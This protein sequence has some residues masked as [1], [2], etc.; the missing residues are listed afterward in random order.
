MIGF[1]LPGFSNG[2]IGQLSDCAPL[3]AL[4]ITRPNTINAFL[5]ILLAVGLLPAAGCQLP[6]ALL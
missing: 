4:A 1:T 5:T 6:A 2:P 3:D